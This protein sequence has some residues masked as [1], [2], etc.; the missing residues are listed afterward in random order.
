MNNSDKLHAQCMS[1]INIICI[2]ALNFI[3]SFN[4]VELKGCLCWR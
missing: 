1:S 3:M 2:E 4:N